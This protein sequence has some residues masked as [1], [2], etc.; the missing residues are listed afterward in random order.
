MTKAILDKGLST[1]H[2]CYGPIIGTV[3]YRLEDRPE[4]QLR[5]RIFGAIKACVP[6]EFYRQLPEGDVKG[7]YINIV[8][9]GGKESADQII[10]LNKALIAVKRKGA[11]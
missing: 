3:F 10:R 2:I 5:H 8:S 11:R 4:T 9:L 6:K 7:L 1:T